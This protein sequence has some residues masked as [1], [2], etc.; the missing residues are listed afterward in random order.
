MPADALRSPLI[1]GDALVGFGA[2]LYGADK[3]GP[4]G[5]PDRAHELR[6]GV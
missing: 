1:V 3:L 5:A 2:L 6:A 4:D